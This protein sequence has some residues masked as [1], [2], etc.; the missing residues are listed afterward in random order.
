M[1]V[2]KKWTQNPVNIQA[3]LELYQD[4]R[5]ILTVGKIAEMLQTTEHNVGHVV[6]S[7]IPPEELIHHKALRYSA[8]K[9][10]ELN[11]MKGKTGEQ[12][13]NYIGDC[14]DGYGYL[15]RV[16]NGKRQFVHRIV[17][18]EA[19]GLTELPECFHVHHI[20][21]NPHNNAL[22]NLALC[23]PS[24]HQKI[25]SLQVMNAVEKSRRYTLA[26]LH[27]CGISP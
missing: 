22:D 15:T 12:H 19:L 7:H 4:T 20:D 23:T 17:M 14:D 24:G 9:T 18:A 26:Q 11:P 2:S 16:H 5:Q 21:D 10:G 6:K 1:S 25:H 13:H 3:V 27:L 8:S